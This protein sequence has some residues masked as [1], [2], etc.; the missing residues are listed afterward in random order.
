MSPV[1]SFV[2][3]LTH[4]LP[5]PPTHL[6]LTTQHHHTPLNTMTVTIT[7]LM[8]HYNTPSHH[9]ASLSSAAHVL[10]TP[11]HLDPHCLITLSKILSLTFFTP[12]YPLTHTHTFPHTRTPTRTHTHTHAHTHKLFFFY[13]NYFPF[14]STFLPFSFPEGEKLPSHPLLSLSLSLSWTSGKEK[15]QKASEY[16]N[17]ICIFS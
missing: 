3:L 8:R 14:L 7:L 13:F 15:R 2:P 10:I 9:H 5:P 6:P 1:A 11:S 12:A 4:F 16:N 17:L